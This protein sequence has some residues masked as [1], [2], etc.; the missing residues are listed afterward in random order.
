[1]VKYGVKGINVGFG[2][3]TL[4][5]CEMIELLD[6]LI[7][8]PGEGHPYIYP[9]LGTVMGLYRLYRP[10]IAPKSLI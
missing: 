10:H 1:M 6:E 2:L 9:I 8:L 4:V 7:I 5:I 3:W